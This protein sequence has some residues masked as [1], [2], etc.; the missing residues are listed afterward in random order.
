LGLFP[1]QLEHVEQAERPTRHVLAEESS[2]T[3]GARIIG[4]IEAVEKGP[5]AVAKRIERRWLWRVIGRLL[6][7][8][9][10]SR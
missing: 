7:R 10:W 8:L 5:T 2:R 6:T 3:C 1:V 4:D 9:T